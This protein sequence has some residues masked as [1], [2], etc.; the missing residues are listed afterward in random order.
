MTSVC[1]FVLILAVMP[2]CFGQDDFTTLVERIKAVEARDMDHLLQIKQLERQVQNSNE[3]LNLM[4]TT[5]HNLQTEHAT[6]L[7]KL[8]DQEITIAT[9][10]TDLDNQKSISEESSRQTAVLQSTVNG[11]GVTIAKLKKIFASYKNIFQEQS[12]DETENKYHKD[13]KQEDTKEIPASKELSD[14]S[15]SS[16]YLKM[17]SLD[18]NKKNISLGHADM[19]KTNSLHGSLISFVEEKGGETKASQRIK[20]N[21]TRQA[22]LN[23][24][25]SK[26]RAATNFVAFHAVLTPYHIDHLGDNDNIRF[27]RVLLNEGDGYHNQH[28]LFITPKPGFYLFSVTLA[29]NYDQKFYAQLKKNGAPLI[30]LSGNGQAGGYLDQGSVTVVTKLNA[31]DEVWVVHNSP[32]DGSIWGNSFSS[33]TG[34]L[35][36]DFE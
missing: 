4:S 24:V 30:N 23:I 3:K 6:L 21:K 13:I 9:L 34:V 26:Q 33:F 15:F 17:P 32:P 1:I 27:D 20:D 35:L 29:T 16:K 22:G 25:N 5:N 10:R 12:N 7:Q 8:T 18:N 28:G 11:M 19:S 36:A 14:A 2:V 31:G